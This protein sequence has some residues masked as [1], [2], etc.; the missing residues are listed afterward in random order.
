MDLG[1]SFTQGGNFKASTSFSDFPAK[2]V[3]TASFLLSAMFS[4]LRHAVLCLGSRHTLPFQPASCQGT[5]TEMCRNGYG[6]ECIVSPET[7]SSARSNPPPAAPL[8]V[9][10]RALLPLMQPAFELR[11]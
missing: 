6:D 5:R 11:W 9:P 7:L 3:S 2:S 4:S 1:R 10:A 8:P